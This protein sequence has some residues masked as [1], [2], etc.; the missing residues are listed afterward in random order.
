MSRGPRRQMQTQD[1]PKALGLRSEDFLQ[2]DHPVY[3]CA[4]SFPFFLP[5]P[6]HPPLSIRSPPPSPKK[7]GYLKKS[8]PYFNMKRTLPCGKGPPS[9]SVC[10]CSLLAV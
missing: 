1:S 7:G 9:F 5:A 6:T 8:I 10:E 4:I 3:L 2:L